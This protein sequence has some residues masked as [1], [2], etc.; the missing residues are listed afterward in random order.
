ML[1]MAGLWLV[2]QGRLLQGRWRWSWV[3][4]GLAVALAASNPRWRQ[5]GTV[6][7]Y[8]SVVGEAIAGIWRDHVWTGSGPGTSAW[9]YPAYRP[10]WAGREAEAVWQLHTTFGQIVAEGGLVGLA[11]LV[12][13]V[14][15]AG[16]LLWRANVLWPQLDAGDRAWMQA[17]GYGAVGYGAL[18]LTDYQLDVPVISSLGII[19]LGVVLAILTPGNAPQPGSRRPWLPVGLG[20][21]WLGLMAVQVPRYGAWAV[22]SSGFQALSTRPEETRAALL[23]AQ[24]WQPRD[25]FYPLMLGYL[26]RDPDWLRRAQTLAPM[27]EYLST[28]LGWLMWERDPAEAAA[29]FQRSVELVPARPFVLTGWGISRL[30]QG[31]PGLPMLVADVMRHPHLI[32]SPWY[33]EHLSPEERQ[34]WQTLVLQTYGDWIERWPQLTFLRTNGA[35]VAWYLGDL[36]LAQQWHPA[37]MD[38]LSALIAARADRRDQTI[39]L[40]QQ[41]Q[42]NPATLLLMAWADPTHRPQWLGGLGDP[43]FA[44]AVAQSL[45]GDPDLATWMQAPLWQQT[46]R[47]SR[48]YVVLGTYR[49]ADAPVVADLMPIPINR[50]IQDYWG[51]PFTVPGF[52]PAFD[53]AIQTLYADP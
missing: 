2:W 28:N 22:A 52:S 13:L 14:A 43:G 26:T 51:D 38:L 25:P 49:R 45:L 18:A 7:S 29:Q 30:R 33:R 53:Q 32:A 41:L 37:Q 42:P 27:E 50:L 31:Q 1:L 20:L 5:L 12:G 11:M 35:A 19:L 21:L 36:S 23:T 17:L 8:R 3:G 9:I 48:G 6:S 44:Q 39:Q 15:M 10:D 4:V 24:R 47:P 16:R 46:Y 34:T 40:L